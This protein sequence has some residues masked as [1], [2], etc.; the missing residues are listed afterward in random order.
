MDQPRIMIPELCNTHQQLLVQQAGYGPNDIWRA[1]LM[2][3]S[4]ALFQGASC[5]PK[6]HA[7]AGGQI[8]NISKL[9]CLACRKPDLFGEIVEVAKT[10]DLGKVKALGDAWVEARQKKEEAQ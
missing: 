5:D 10:H 7:E 2:V 9:G 6:V 4:I 8:E 1:A 3:T